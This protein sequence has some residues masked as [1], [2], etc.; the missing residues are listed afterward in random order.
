V[1]RLAVTIACF[2]WLTLPAA[3]QTKSLAA[4]PESERV[5]VN[6][7]RV[8]PD[9]AVHDFVES[10]PAP[11]AV[12]GK[13]ARWRIAACPVTVGL[14]KTMSAFVTARVKAVASRVGAPVAAGCKPNIDIVFTFN[15]QRLMDQVRATSPF[16]LGYHDDAQAERVAQVVHPVQAWYTTQTTDLIGH[17]TI[18]T[19]QIHAGV[20]SIPTIFGNAYVPEI[21][22]TQV[23]GFRI[24]DGLSDELYHVIIVADLAAVGKEPIGPVADYIAML[25]LAQTGS[26]DA[27]QPMASI[28]NLMAS[29]CDGRKP[30]AITDFDLAYLRALYCID[31]RGSA[32]AQRGDIA[33]R[34]KKSLEG[35]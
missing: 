8:A 11:A 16:L 29:G 35:G 27:C 15:P 12:S 25:A 9:A 33:S 24:G 21:P 14:P 28:V 1:R 18:D 3:G 23:T 4:S 10:Y 19:K 30:D 32:G 2:V 26:F 20:I 7:E 34:M 5:I 22:F 17:P 13:I 6:G 31:P